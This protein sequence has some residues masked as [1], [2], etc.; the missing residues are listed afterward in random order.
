MD[1][2]DDLAFIVAFYK[3]HEQFTFTATTETLSRR[4]AFARIQVNSRY[5]LRSCGK[6][7]I[8]ALYKA[9]ECAA[10][11]ALTGQKRS[12]YMRGFFEIYRLAALARLP[13]PVYTR[14]CADEPQL[15]TSHVDYVIRI[16]HRDIR[17]RSLAGMFTRTI[18]FLHGAIIPEA[19]A[20]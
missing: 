9:A 7:E 1:V 15:R 6:T 17:H 20:C 5:S 18:D 12:T 4:T 14:E 10:I 2:I 19:A 13:L 8:D 3:P 16:G 11:Y